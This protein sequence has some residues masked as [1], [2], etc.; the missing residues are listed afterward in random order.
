MEGERELRE[1]L[2]AAGLPR[3]WMAVRV[4]LER[5]IM[6]SSAEDERRVCHVYPHVCMS[7]R[8]VY[9]HAQSEMAD[10]ERETEVSRDEEEARSR[11]GEDVCPEST[12]EGADGPALARVRE[13]AVVENEGW[14]CGLYTR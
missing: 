2:S 10:G 6:P 12:R 11:L 9:V 13:R 1:K 4:A 7:V 3:E 5:A 8:D 14:R